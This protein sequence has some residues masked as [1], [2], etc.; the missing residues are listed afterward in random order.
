[1]TIEADIA[2][3]GSLLGDPTRATMLA[4]VNEGRA[5]T[6]GELSRASGVTPATAS[7]HLARLT[8]G[9]LLTFTRQGRH[10]YYRIASPEVGELLEAISLLAPPRSDARRATPRVP[11]ELR[12]A[13]TCYD[14]IAG[15]LGVGIADKLVEQ[16]GLIFRGEHGELT[17]E[18]RRLLAPFEPPPE[19]P[20]GSR[21]PYCRACTDWSERRPHIAGVLGR[22]ILERSLTLGWVRRAVAGRGLT[23]TLE[24]RSGFRSLLGLEA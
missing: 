13:R 21:R 24:G 5:L 9:G 4:Q 8:E 23:I 14:H 16:G 19:G 17:G 2:A 11:P 10:R 18:G 22:H 1:M 7:E 6:A 20:A 12:K 15:E 3:V